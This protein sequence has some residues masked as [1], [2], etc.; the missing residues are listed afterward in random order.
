MSGA[1]F[2]AF[3]AGAALGASLIIAIG[4]QNAFV[5]RQGLK[6]EHVLAVVATCV[7]CDVALITLGAIGFGTLIGRFP[8]ITSIAAWAGAAFLLA[9]GALAFRSAMRPSSMHSEAPERVAATA[10]STGAVVLTTLAV[11]LLNPHVYLD[12]VVL[13][14][15]LAAQYEPAPRV[16]FALGAATASFAWFFALGFGARVLAPLF[17][18]PGAWR[19]LDTIIGVIM[20]SIAVSLVIGQFR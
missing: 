10:T 8:T 12:T 9:Y 1:S 17:D 19:V 18:R 3:V 2:S 11:S 15:S 14:G 20:W 4:A 13:I 5:L 6:R 7:I 16:L